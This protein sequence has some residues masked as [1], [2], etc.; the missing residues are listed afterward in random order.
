M[1]GNY[2]YQNAEAIAVFQGKDDRKVLLSFDVPM[3][4]TLDFLANVTT[5]HREK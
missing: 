5:D 1:T 2:F 4:E 3:G